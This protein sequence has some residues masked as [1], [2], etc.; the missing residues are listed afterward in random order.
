MIKHKQHTPKIHDAAYVGMLG[1][2]CQL[3]MALLILALVE[4]VSVTKPVH[5]HQ[6]LACY[7]SWGDTF[8][9]AAVPNG[10]SVNHLGC[11]QAVVNE[12]TT[13]D[14]TALQKENF[15]LRKELEMYRELQ[16]VG[17]LV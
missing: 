14:A 17:W 15:R 1:K 12:D 8:C 4:L 2:C 10:L 6:T 3:L 16:K 11:L 7:H 13:A 5:C 9:P